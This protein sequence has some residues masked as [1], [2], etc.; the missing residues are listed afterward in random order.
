MMADATKLGSAQTRQGP[1]PWILLYK[2]TYIL[3]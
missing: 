3:Q 1:S 2:N